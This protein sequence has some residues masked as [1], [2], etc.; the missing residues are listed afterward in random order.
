MKRKVYEEAISDFLSNKSSSL[1]QCAKKFGLP[2]STLYGVI[3]ANRGFLGQGNQSKVFDDEHEIAKKVLEKTNHGKEL[4]WPL[5]KQ[6][7]L[8]ELEQRRST[9]TNNDICRVSTTSG[10]LLNISFVRRFAERNGLSKYLL[11]KF[12]V[13]D[14][15]YRCELCDKSFIWKKDLVK[16]ERT[17]HK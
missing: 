5:Q 4:S 13:T 14:R 11:K 7:L 9:N 16:H 3:M 1:M 17:K 8:D 2:K 10:T 15:P 6:L 12:L